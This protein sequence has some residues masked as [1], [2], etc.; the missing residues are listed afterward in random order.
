MFICD[1]SFKNYFSQ[2][3]CLLIYLSK[4]LIWI[5]M[6]K[7]IV[8]AIMQWLGPLVYTQN[9]RGSNPNPMHFEGSVLTLSELST[10]CTMA[11][12][13]DSQVRAMLY[14]LLLT[15]I[16]YSDVS[17]SDE[18]RTRKVLSVCDKNVSAFS[19]NSEILQH[20][21]IIHLTFISGNWAWLSYTKNYTLLLWRTER[22]RQ[23]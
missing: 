1:L 13:A 11:W 5:S 4:C 18:C 16:S 17:H 10:N 12:V 22:L 14:A 8:A 21:Q 2:F 6:T 19:C 7:E 9:V 20:Q 3:E 23:P 15:F